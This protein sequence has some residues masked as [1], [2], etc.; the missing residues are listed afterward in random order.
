MSQGRGTRPV[1][2]S[3]GGGFQTL[4]RGAKAVRG[5]QAKSSRS[6]KRMV[7]ELARKG[8]DGKSMDPVKDP[9]NAVG[10]AIITGFFNQS[11]LTI[12][13]R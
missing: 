6:G 1:G 12:K 3:L 8:K 13:R 9:L 5:Q 2:P 7:N 11:N 4:N 10:M